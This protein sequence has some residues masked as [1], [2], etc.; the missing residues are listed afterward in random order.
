[1][2]ILLMI[3]VGFILDLL[4]G[5]P[6]S[7]PHPVKLIG[8]VISWSVKQIERKKRSAR[9][10]FLLGT[11]MWF[12]VI[13]STALISG[14]ILYVA[15]F[16][17]WLYLVIGTYLAYTTISIKGLATEAHKIMKSLQKDDLVLARKQ[18]S[19]IVGRDTNELNEDEITKA[20][21]ETIA[22]NIND[23][24]IAP[25][26]FL[27]I[28]GPVLGMVYKAVNTLDSMVGYQNQRF[29]D[30]GKTSALLDDVIGFIPAR[31]TWVL[32]IITSFI[33]RLDHHNAV[34]VGLRDHLKHNSPNSAYPESVIAGA[35]DLQLG[36]PH[37]Y[38]GKVVNKPFI[39]LATEKTATNQ[40]IFKTI[41]VLYVTSFGGLIS[42][43]L[44]RWVII[45]LMGNPS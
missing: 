22:E 21:I 43:G 24:V 34:K 37:Y 19:M 18:L 1:M 36:G 13:L 39:G 5:D 40:D 31:L 12:G 3:T 44:I 16:Y 15:D 25:L 7:W 23:G 27:M 32:M 11:L 30:L 35:L 2:D 28:G 26:F 8:K 17:H 6:H 4:I 42:F 29:A 38:F 9:Q 10:K 33:L 14:A 41:Q 45:F 20:T